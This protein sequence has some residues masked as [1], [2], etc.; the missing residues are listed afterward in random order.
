VAQE[1]LTDITT[2]TRP[3]RV[4]LDVPA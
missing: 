4:E 1:A 2:H 3:D